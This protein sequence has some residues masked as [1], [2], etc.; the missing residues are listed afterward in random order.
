MPSPD[1]LSLAKRVVE[2]GVCQRAE[3]DECLAIQRKSEQ[4]G[5]LEL[6]GDLLVQRGFLTKSQLARLL[7]TGSIVP[8]Q[9]VPSTL[10]LG[11]EE[12][13]TSVSLPPPIEPL[14][15][16]NPVKGVDEPREGLRER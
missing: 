8:P 3:V 14:P 10:R 12:N 16:D 6:L 2:Q 15:A 7:Q 9:T 4:N 11:P 1:D 5:Q 13:D